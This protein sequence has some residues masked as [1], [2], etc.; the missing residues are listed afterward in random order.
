MLDTSRC[1]QSSS[2]HMC[3]FVHVL[4]V[5]QEPVAKD[6]CLSLFPGPAAPV[7]H[8]ECHEQGMM[9]PGTVLCEG[10]LAIEVVNPVNAFAG[11]LLIL[12]TEPAGEVLRVDVHWLRTGG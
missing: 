7:E 5:L 4:K 6:L 2:I 11:G 9:L 1:A 10:E 8:G 3:S 12:E